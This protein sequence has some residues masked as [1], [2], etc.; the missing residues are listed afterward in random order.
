MNWA[1]LLAAVAMVESGDN[2]AAVNRAEG[3]YGILQV[4]QCALD[5]V[6][7]HYGLG[8]R[9][10]DVRVSRDTSRL[11]FILYVRRW[12]AETPEQAARIWN[13]GPKGMEKAAPLDYWSRVRALMEVKSN[14]ESNAQDV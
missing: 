4:R 10:V 11:V 12:G 14:G 7:E 9:M 2:P 5:D 13:G 1:A 8:L 6:N 3:A